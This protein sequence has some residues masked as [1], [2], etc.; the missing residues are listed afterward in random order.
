MRVLE[1][2]VLLAVSSVIMSQAQEA[3]FRGAGGSLGIG[4]ATQHAR[5]MPWTS[6]GIPLLQAEKDA[7]AFGP[8]ASLAG[9]LE[10]GRLGEI[11]VF[12]EMSASFLA[13]SSSSTALHDLSAGNRVLLVAGRPQGVI[14][15]DASGSVASSSVIAPATGTATVIASSTPSGGTQAVFALNR[16]GSSGAYAAVATSGSPETSAAYG[17]VLAPEGFAFAGVGDI[18]GTMLQSSVSRHTFRGGLEAMFATSIPAAEGW[19]VVP[20]LGAAY[21]FAGEDVRHE[22]LID[23]A[24]GPGI[25][26]RFPTVGLRTQE[27]MDTHMVGPLASLST[28]KVLDTRWSATVGV[29]AGWLLTSTQW[30]MDATGIMEGMADIGLPG[31]EGTSWGGTG[32]FRLKGG[33]SFVADNGTVFSL[34]GQVEHLTAVPTTSTSG[35]TAASGSG[36]LNLDLP[37]RSPGITTLTSTPTF[38]YAVSVSLSRRF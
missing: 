20:R 19:S 8:A 25:P 16:N 37:A 38:G 35:D 23:P 7:M 6:A 34:N 33:V 3:P 24:E 12:V 9:A 15:L 5:G 17:G 21:R 18:S 13:A 26:D 2:S 31:Q 30:R 32:L 14:E 4:F 22:V 27:R 1:L 36:P 10:L 11:P 28:T 29:D